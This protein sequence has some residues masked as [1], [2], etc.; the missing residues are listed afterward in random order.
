MNWNRIFT[1]RT[2][3]DLLRAMRSKEMHPTIQ[4]CILLDIYLLAPGSMLSQASSLR[5]FQ[6]CQLNRKLYI[7]YI[8]RLRICWHNWYV[9]VDVFCPR[10]SKVRWFNGN[11]CENGIHEGWYAC[12]IH[13]ILTFCLASVWTIVR[14][15]GLSL[16][17]KRK[18]K[19]ACVLNK[20]CTE[21][22]VNDIIRAALFLVRLLWTLLYLFYISFFSSFHA[23]ILRSYS[24]F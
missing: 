5:S 2:G 15:F 16:Q 9:F 20:S 7:F 24:I 18:K 6:I 23:S 22:V 14:W 11:K 12:G 17:H 1:K 8:I 10:A 13:L 3:P 21:W 4:T 19:I